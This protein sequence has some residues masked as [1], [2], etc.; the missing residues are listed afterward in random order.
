MFELG[1]GKHA[2]AHS[3]NALLGLSSP[4]PAGGAH[5]LA[6]AVKA[7]QGL[8]LALTL[9]SQ[10]SDK[11]GA[12]VKTAGPWILGPSCTVNPTL[13]FCHIAL[14]ICQHPF[15]SLEQLWLC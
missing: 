7:Q 11:T 9:E 12:K 14:F 3:P 5:T 6:R 8:A 4:L 13:H 15:L 2:C 1:K 10:Q